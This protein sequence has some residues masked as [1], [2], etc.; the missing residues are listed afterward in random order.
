M[1]DVPERD[2]RTPRA[3]QWPK[4]GGLSRD[5][6]CNDKTFWKKSEVSKKPGPWTG[7]F[8]STASWCRRV[9]DCAWHPHWRG[10]PRRV[11]VAFQ[12]VA[13]RRRTPEAMAPSGGATRAREYGS[14]R[15]TYDEDEYNF[16]EEYGRLSDDD[17]YDPMQ[18]V[19]DDLRKTMAHAK[20]ARS[21]KE[22]RRPVKEVSTLNNALQAMYEDEVAF[23]D[24]EQVVKDAASY[25]FRDDDSAEDTSGGIETSNSVFTLAEKRQGA[26]EGLRAKARF[27]HATT[28]A[29]NDVKQK[30]IVDYG[31]GAARI[32]RWRGERR[33]V[34]IEGCDDYRGADCGGYRGGQGGRD[35]G[36][37]RYSA[38]GTRDKGRFAEKY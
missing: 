12:L 1:A 11:G 36:Y 38:H 25:R 29:Q 30:L 37:F 17:A 16:E 9:R 3:V 31:M 15:V 32:F 28:Y 7:L 13:G 2:V 35:F 24:E 4:N 8:C 5:A 20:S 33:V 34:Q 23:F 10:V 26:L 21:T 27:K 18:H 19:Q 22:K 14:R 6:T